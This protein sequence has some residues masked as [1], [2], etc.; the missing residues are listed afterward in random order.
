M[1]VLDTTIM[2][3]LLKDDKETKEKIRSLEQSD[4]KISTTAI[5]VYEL[6]K[7]AQ[8][9]SRREENLAKVRDL[10]SSLEV[11]GVSV[12]ACEEAAKIYRELREKGRMIGE[13][14]ILI[15]SI[16]RSSD[17]ALVTSDEDFRSVRGLEIIKW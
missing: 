14:D 11:L 15:A 5:T 13:F 7:G 17:E 9:S 3:S 2:V 6:L 16:T 10:V 8:I 1:P 12:G 4:A